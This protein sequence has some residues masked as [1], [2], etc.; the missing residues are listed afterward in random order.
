LK[1]II[2]VLGLI[3]KDTMCCSEPNIHKANFVTR[4]FEQAKRCDYTKTSV[5][6]VK[7]RMLQI[8]MALVTKNNWPMLPHVPRWPFSMVIY[9]KKFS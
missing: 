9:V 2:V 4:G 1:K 8:F 7:W 3:E 5:H 6:V